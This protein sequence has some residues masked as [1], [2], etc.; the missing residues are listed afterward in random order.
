MSRSWSTF[1]LCW[2]SARPRCGSPYSGKKSL[3]G[4]RK[5]KADVAGENV[6]I[7]LSRAW[8]LFKKENIFLY[9]EVLHPR[10]AAEREYLG[11][12]REVIQNQKNALKRVVSLES[13]DEEHDDEEELQLFL[14]NSYKSF[15]TSILFNEG[16][17]SGRVRVAVR[18]RP[19]N[20]E[21]TVM[22]VDF[23]DC[24]ELQL[25][26][27]FNGAP[28]D[29]AEPL[30]ETN[31]VVL[32]ANFGRVSAAMNKTSATKLQNSAITDRP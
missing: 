16:V 7:I 30:N 3:V 18:L 5:E 28:K 20:A 8:E 32:Y 13:D 2:S 14:I 31:F 1:W 12:E 26:E 24:V 6:G 4:R 27:S 19:Q 10:S 29:Q 22:D 15:F 17:V 23:V 21:E 9:L 11:F 25:E